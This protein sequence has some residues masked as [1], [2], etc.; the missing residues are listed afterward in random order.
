MMTYL[1]EVVVREVGE[2]REDHHPFQA[3]LIVCPHLELV[4]QAHEHHALQ[5]T[6]DPL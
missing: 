6:I 2:G 1:E 5:G 4:E 3:Q